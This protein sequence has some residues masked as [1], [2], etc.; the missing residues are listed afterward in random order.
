MQATQTQLIEIASDP[1]GGATVSRT[2]I[3]PRGT[4]GAQAIDRGRRWQVT[5]YL[6]RYQTIACT[7]AEIL[8]GRPTADAQRA[9]DLVAEFDATA[10][11]SEAHA[12]FV[13]AVHNIALD[14]PYPTDALAPYDIDW[15]I[16][17]AF[18]TV[19]PVAPAVAQP[20]TCRHGVSYSDECA[21]CED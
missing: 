11:L 20:G 6:T 7:V 1:R 15:P 9:A 16:H 3:V 14:S 8:G 12:L 18:D 2:R 10:A 21:E 13:T 4:A 19:F 17:E 5:Y